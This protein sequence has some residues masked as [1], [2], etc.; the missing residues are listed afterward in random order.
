MAAPGAAH[1]ANPWAD[2]VVSYTQ[3]AGAASGYNKPGVALGSPE[4]VTGEGFGFP[5]SVTPF[6][7][8]FGTDEI[9][10]IGAGGSLVV[11]FDEAVTDDPLNPYGIDLLV[12]GNSFFFDP[13]FAPVASA[14]WEPAGMVEVSQ[15]GIAWTLAPGVIADGV[16]PTL[17]YLDETNPFGGPAGSVASDFTRPVD[18]SFNWTGQGLG[19][20]IAGY[21]GSGGGSGVDI[22]A[23]GLPWIRYVRVSVAAGGVK[24]EIDAFS[25]VAPIPTP[26][27]LALAMVGSVCGVRRRRN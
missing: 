11:E 3:G 17:G 25:D 14:I 5:G 23:L 6:S 27:A 21:D 7:G 24:A 18:P 10:S 22:G 26:G 19:G 20:L 4:R 13:T 9:V 8:P 15:D 2:K 12:F 1:G 16:F